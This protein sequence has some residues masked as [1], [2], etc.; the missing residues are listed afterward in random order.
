VSTP[1]WLPPLLDVDW[2]KYDET[3]ERAH[4]VFLADFGN[5]KTRPKFRG[6]RLGLKKHPEFQGKAATFWHFVT[7]GPLEEDRYA[8]RERLERVGWAKA[9]IVNVDDPKRVRCWCAEKAG[10]PRWH[11]ALLDFSYLVVLADRGTYVLPWTA[12]HVDSDH[13]RKKLERAWREWAEAQPQKS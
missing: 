6:R 2:N 8:V 12:F 4:A 13:Q 9:L 3:I 7:E 1:S 11:L 5:E 10:E